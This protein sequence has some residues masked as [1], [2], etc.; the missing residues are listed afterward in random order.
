MTQPL[1]TAEQHAQLPAV[2]EARANGQSIDP[3][4]VCGYS[5]GRAR[6]LVAGRVLI[7]YR[8]AIRPPA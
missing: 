2:G 4:P 7:P 1:I 5:P 6:D 8:C 3:M